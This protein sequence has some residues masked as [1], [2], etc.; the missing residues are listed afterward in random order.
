MSNRYDAIVIGSGHNGLV[1][2]LR[3]AK[4]GRK[5]LVLERRHLLGGVA[6]TEEL[7]PGFRFNIGAPNANL[8]SPQVLA[9][10]GSHAPEFIDSPVAAFAPLAD[11]RS[12]TLWRD[13]ERTAMELAQFSAKDAQAY[14]EFTRQAERFAGVLSQM[15]QLRP[16]NL[17]TNPPGLL[18]AW[19][20]LALRLRGLGGSDMMEFMRVLPMDADNW[21]NEHFETEALKGLYA[22]YSTTG[23]MQGPRA[24]GTAFML[25]YQLMGGQA[26]RAVRGGVG[27]ISAA[28]AAAA[29]AQ[30]VEIR[31]EA[32]VRRILAADGRVRGVELGV[33][34]RF[35][36]PAG[37]Q[38]AAGRA[39]SDGG[40][41]IEAG[42]VL[43]NAD[44][45]TTF[46]H[47]LGPALL[48]PRIY[49][50]LRSL[51][52]RGSTA[53]VHFA[54]SALPEFAATGG[55][56]VRLQGD[57]IISPS[58]DY[59]ERAYDDAKHGRL[60]AQPVLIARIPSLLD[61][62]LAPSG[63][64]VMSVTVRYAPY[65]VNKYTGKQ[66][67]KGSEASAE[68][69]DAWRE[70]LGDLVTENIAQF[71][72]NL[73]SLISHRAILTPLDYERTY[74][75]AEGSEMHG[76]MGLDQLLLQRPAPGFVGY[77]SPIAGLYLCGAGAHPGG[78]LTGLPGLLAAQQALGES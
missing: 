43:S 47:L 36:T 28:L 50:R 63:Q 34:P 68:N 44:P 69:W 40:E 18:A 20:R 78:G 16:P 60:S 22:A 27:A 24:S 2:A 72:P 30:G 29:R 53:S 38:A 55:E 1:A 15:A 77:R 4:A 61:S 17:S 11:G 73:Q 23:L 74:G 7:I 5:V 46:L 33:N 45:R 58:A 37:G 57:I 25:L 49:R 9:L 12:L 35:P 39:H 65:K 56:A 52:L 62:S 8:L 26:A 13:K 41:I 48:P 19:A 67:D 42:M 14:W 21:L 66:V 71:A 32:P 6:A 54:L 10:L 59:A 75:L 64:H 51:K 3:L 70:P 31:T 76:Q